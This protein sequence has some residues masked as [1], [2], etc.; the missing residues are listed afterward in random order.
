MVAIVGQQAFAG[1][2]ASA[3]QETDLHSLLKDVAA[4]YIETIATPEQVRH[5]FDRAFRIAH[6][7]RT[8]TAIILPHDVQRQAVDEPEHKHGRQHSLAG[9]WEPRVIPNDEDLK[10]AAEVLN[11]GQRV[12]M[13]VGAGALGATAEV[14]AIAER[15]GA[16]IAK[17]LLGK[18]AV[19][20]DLPF[21][22]GSVGWLGTE[23]SNRIMEEC[24]TLLMIGSTMPYAEFL[25]ERSIRRRCSRRSSRCRTRSRPTGSSIGGIRDG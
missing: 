19:P 23:A 11:A 4:E 5:V 12:A 17:A 18:A 8:V 20:D 22:T 3:Q 9:W 7:R 25:P 24:D 21:V 15:L 16:G 10:Y 14:I 2:G 1:V 13:L 6:G